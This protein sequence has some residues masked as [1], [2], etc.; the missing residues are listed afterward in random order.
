MIRVNVGTV[1]VHRVFNDNG[2]SVNV[3]Y[4]EAYNRL[5]LRDK[6]MEKEE[7]YVYG[8]C[9]EIVKVKGTIDLPITIKEEHLSATQD[10][11]FMVIDQ[12]SS[13]NIL[14]GRPFLKEMRVITFVHYLSIKFPT[15]YG[16][17][18]IRM[19]QE[20]YKKCYDDSMIRF[21]KKRDTDQSK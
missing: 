18:C 1:S 2:S 14:L 4:Y 17:G 13:Y 12:E 6:D 19:Q 11:Q 8:F 15:P 10:I 16:T 5:G 7:S 3:L 21:Q 9:G 20:D